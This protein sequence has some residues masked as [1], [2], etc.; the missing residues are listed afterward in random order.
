MLLRR[1]PR[2]A[3][4]SIRL[5][6]N[7]KVSS[8][9]NGVEGRVPRYNSES[10]LGIALTEPFNL[11]QSYV[12]Q[13]LIEKDEQQLRAMKEFQKLYY[14]LLGYKPP[15]ELQV[16]ISLLL[17]QIE[18]KYAEIG[19]QQQGIS[20]STMS[21]LFKKDPVVKKNELIAY[22]TDEQQL[23]NI[24]APKGLLIN[25]E[26]GC[27]KSML[28]DIFAASLPYESKMRWH[29]NTFIL[30]VFSQI[31]EIQNQRNLL[32]HIGKDN[33]H[34]ME[35]EFI[36]FEIAQ[37]MIAKNTVLILDEFML[38]DIALANII[39]ILFTYYFKLGG[40]LVATSNKL[41]E[42][43]YSNKFQKNSFEKFVNIL[44]IR[45]E[46]F[47]MR[48]ETD[49][50]EKF[51]E[52]STTKANLVVKL[53]NENHEQ[54]WQDMIT[55]IIGDNSPEQKI[56]RV[57]GRDIKI[58]KLY[59]DVCFLDYQEICQ[60]L[61]SSADYITIASSFPVII[62]DNVL[63]MTTKM[64]NEAKRFISLIDAVYESKCQFYMRSEV[65]I[66]YLFFADALY[67]EDKV[68][69]KRLNLVVIEED[70]RIKVQDEEMYAKTA[71]AMENPYRPN[72]SSY[73]GDVNLTFNEDINKKADYQ[74]YIA[75]TGE[76]EK[77][78]YKR[79]VSR[80]KEMVGSDL[81]RERSQWVPVDKSMRPWEKENSKSHLIINPLS[82][83]KNHTNTEVDIGK[84][85]QMKE[86]IKDEY[87][88]DIVEGSGI[89]LQEFSNEI[90]PKFKEVSH[91]WK[92]GHWTKANGKR[93]KD[94]LAKSWLRS[95][96]K[97]D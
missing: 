75:F 91:F 59:G 90:S 14:R 2:V 53:E 66:D 52:N 28:M 12:L 81:W 58:N 60:G 33:K 86:S 89:T 37:K 26:V 82:K 45:C 42:E 30:W 65:E 39:K 17:K 25:G 19:V 49:Y 95:S 84:I 20:F 43:L 57:Y 79:V 61:Y 54:E 74:N 3:R 78:A 32:S 71:I 67:G 34:L 27:G 9:P 92:M 51:L 64:K 72:V 56:L 8:G 47:D 18:V 23:E 13:G 41:P 38:P 5:S 35:N 1:V 4:I 63:L 76:D 68:L 96:I 36:L 31:H 40:V 44:N 6:L 80:I 62:L 29:Y 77:F 48:S 88:R 15:E 55:S 50:R 7:V 87:P 83:I 94:G 24:V 97:D 22:L 85:H 21:R 69:M 70:D 11:Y 73:E 16:K 93:L 10:S 46:S